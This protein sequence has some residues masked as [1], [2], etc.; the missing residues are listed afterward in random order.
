MPGKDSALKA[1][2]IRQS[3]HS[4]LRYHLPR[5]ERCVSTLS[6][7]EVWSRPNPASN[8]IGNLLLH[9]EGNVRQWIMSGLGSAPDRRR[10]DLEFSEPGPLPR[11]VTLAHLRKTVQAAA[12]VLARL[13]ASD[14][15]RHYEIQGFRVTGLEAV[16][17]VTEHFAFHTGQIIYATKSLR[18]EDLGFTRLPGEK[19]T[20]KNRLPAL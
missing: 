7:A 12:R 1:E 10:R 2:F 13:S 8:S 5:I 16:F 9:L 11:A 19:R 4:L 20:A 3:R 6:E 14:L 17:H 18:G 15:A